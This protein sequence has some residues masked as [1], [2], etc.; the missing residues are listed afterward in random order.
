LRAAGWRV[1]TIWECRLKK[2]PEAQIARVR[3]VLKG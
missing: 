3:R 2:A 1:I